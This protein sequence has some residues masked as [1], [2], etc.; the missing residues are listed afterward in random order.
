MKY[1]LILMLTVF[2]AN[3]FAFS[4]AEKKFLNKLTAVVESG[5]AIESEVIFSELSPK[6]QSAL[7]EAAEDESN[8]W[9]DTILE[10]DYQLKENASVEFGSLS[11]IFSAQG[12][13]IAYR[14]TIQHEAYDTGSCDVPYDE[15]ESV[16]QE[17]MKDNCTAGYIFSGIYISPDFK[18]HLRDENA[19]EDFKD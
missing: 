13:F 4:K 8:I 7:L 3:S 18:F 1:L 17:Y 16:I 5:T 6:E 10:G 14:G 19:I 15:E 11:K 12:E 9:Y 2:S